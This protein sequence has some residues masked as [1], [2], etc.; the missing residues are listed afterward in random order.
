M[1]LSAQVIFLQEIA[2]LLCKYLIST[3]MH[4]Y[5][6]KYVYMYTKTVIY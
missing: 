2:E 5:I 6:H 4:M 1:R 3:K